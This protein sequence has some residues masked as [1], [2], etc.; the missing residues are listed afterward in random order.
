M[1]T[2]RWDNRIYAATAQF[3]RILFV[4][5]LASLESPSKKCL[6]QPN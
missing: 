5:E 1:A 3:V 6:R 2:A 4:G